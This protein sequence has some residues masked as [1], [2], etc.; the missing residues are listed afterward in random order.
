[1]KKLTPIDVATIVMLRGLGFQEKEIAAKLNVTQSAVS[2]Q[3]M[4]IRKEALQYGVDE[5]FRI[6]CAWLN[7]SVWR[8]KGGSI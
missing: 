5:T 8:V 4:K 6:H 1:M 3:L 7:V 2:H